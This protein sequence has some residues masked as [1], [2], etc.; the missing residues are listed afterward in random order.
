[1]KNRITK[2]EIK[3]NTALFAKNRKREKA[4]KAADRRKGELLRARELYDAWQKEFVKEGCFADQV[5]AR[6]EAFRRLLRERVKDRDVRRVIIGE[7]HWAEVKFIAA[8]GQRLNKNGN[9]RIGKG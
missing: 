1:M 2:K 5:S 3:D 8:Y 7:L 6:F 9:G 4:E